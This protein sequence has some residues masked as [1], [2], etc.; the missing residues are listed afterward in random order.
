[1]NENNLNDHAEGPMPPPAR[2]P[3]KRI[4]SQDWEEQKIQ[5]R[6]LYLDANL[7]IS[8]VA[9][10]M[11]EKYKFGAGCVSLIIVY[12][13]E[14]GIV[15]A[16]DQSDLFIREKQFKRKVDEWGFTKN[17]TNRE[18]MKMVQKRKRREDE[19]GKA[20]IFKRSRNGTDFEEVDLAKLDRFQKRNRLEELEV[21]SQS[22]GIS[23]NNQT[24]ITA[25]R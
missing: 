22:S 4:S 3:Y 23:H 9:K 14:S 1:M 18:M 17:I 11:L 13:D 15:D 6:N 2:R 16:G 20:T 19:H 7:S 24:V 21:V 25:D 12:I 10:I 8:E 5:I